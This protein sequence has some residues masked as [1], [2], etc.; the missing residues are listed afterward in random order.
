M[1]G[2]AALIEAFWSPSGVPVM[3]KYVVGSGLWV[4]VFLYLG[5]AGRGEADA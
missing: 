1:L 5:L 2:I 4:L 3:L